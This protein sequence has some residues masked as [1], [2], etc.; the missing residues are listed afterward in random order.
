MATETLSD[1][2]MS[3]EFD[4]GVDGDGNA[5]STRKSFNNIKTTATHDQCY[6][7]A[8]ALAP[9]QQYDVASIERENTFVLTA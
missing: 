8:Q 7:V 5:V 9:L 3:I 2:R 1:S 4:A 6:N